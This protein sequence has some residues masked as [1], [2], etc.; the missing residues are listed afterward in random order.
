MS[1]L[2]R[3]R[4]RTVQAVI[5]GYFLYCIV[6]AMV[7]WTMFDGALAV[8]LWLLVS[9]GPVVLYGWRR[10]IADLLRPAMTAGRDELVRQLGPLATVGYTVARDV[11]LGRG[12]V[13]VLV[14]GPSGIYAV[15]CSAW[16]GSFALRNAKLTRSG[17]SAQRLVDRTTAAADLAERRLALQGVDADVTAVLALT[18]SR[19]RDGSIS[20]RRVH[21]MQSDAIASWIHRRPVRLETSGIE[22][23]AHALV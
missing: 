18:R 15:E 10:S 21:V 1:E 8:P 5:V 16:P 12:T 22:R 17:V 4:A 11:D 7:I 13:D 3:A 2:T 20:L 19:L 14:V 23:A 9:V 6:A